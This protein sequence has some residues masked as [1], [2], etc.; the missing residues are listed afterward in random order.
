MHCSGGGEV[1]VPVLVVSRSSGC[2]YLW[3][4][5]SKGWQAA[6]QL[7]PAA[8]RLLPAV[9]RLLPAARCQSTPLAPRI[10][11]LPPLILNFCLPLQHA[12]WAG[13]E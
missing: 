1:C 3:L 6:Q 8:C 12:V 2:E 13:T 5:Y 7:L 10:V 9:C 11:S 4:A